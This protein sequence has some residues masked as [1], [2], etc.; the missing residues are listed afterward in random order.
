MG[1]VKMPDAVLEYH[2]KSLKES[3]NLAV[4]PLSAVYAEH[5]GAQGGRGRGRATTRV[6]MPSGIATA[7]GREDKTLN[8]RSQRTQRKELAFAA[9]D[10]LKL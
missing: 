9:H 10:N 3:R 8:R 1:K 6:H 5:A 2:I 7:E 4:P